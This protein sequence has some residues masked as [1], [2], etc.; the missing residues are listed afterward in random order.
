MSAN[1]EDDRLK[2]EEVALM[3]GVLSNLLDNALRYGVAQDEP[4]HITVS[5]TESPHAVTLTVSDNGPGVSAAQLKRLTR[6]W[7]QGSAGEALKEGAGLG[8]AI[9]RE[10]AQQHGAE[11]DIF[12][13]PRATQ[14]K[15]PGSLFRLTFPFLLFVSLTALAGGAL[16]DIGIYNLAVTRW[17]LQQVHGGTC[18]E[19]T[20]WD[21]DA[22]LAAL[23]VQRGQGGHG[24]GKQ[25]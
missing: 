16:W 1:S 9:V 7:V 20:R 2:G 17:V 15:L 10:I 22:V 4:A 25:T 24:Q 21:V 19:P 13:N 14:P 5:V 12:S 3:D 23:R 18:P 8:L 11:V 6:R